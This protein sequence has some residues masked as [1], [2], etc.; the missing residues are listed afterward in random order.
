M[1]KLN[2]FH[3]QYIYKKTTKQHLS[4]PLIEILKVVDVTLVKIVNGS[5]R[6]WFV[7]HYALV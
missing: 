5:R 3:L 1:A 2:M 6:L 4:N 7:C